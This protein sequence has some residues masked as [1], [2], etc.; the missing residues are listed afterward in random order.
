MGMCR[1][2]E[3]FIIRV[4]CVTDIYFQVADCQLRH[5]EFQPND[6]EDVFITPENES[7]LC[8]QIFR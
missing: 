1:N 3:D 2:A 7:W 8:W 4:I 6:H 5:R